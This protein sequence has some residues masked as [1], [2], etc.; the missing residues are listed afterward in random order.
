MMQSE[1]GKSDQTASA[2][3]LHLGDFSVTFGE[4]DVGSFR[5]YMSTYRDCLEA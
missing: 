5:K 4:H 1:V 3:T 2:G